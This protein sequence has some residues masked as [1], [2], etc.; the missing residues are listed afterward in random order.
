MLSSC[1]A[2]GEGCGGASVERGLRYSRKG[3]DIDSGRTRWLGLN[4]RASAF[5]VGSVW[6]NMVRR[7]D[8]TTIGAALCDHCCIFGRR[9]SG[10]AVMGD[11]FW[12]RHLV[13]VCGAVERKVR[14]RLRSAV[15]GTFAEAIL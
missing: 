1:A 2:S 4:L 3:D 8:D 6:M 7:A 11:A 5:G 13:A 10:E 14:E 15:R 12:C 9:C